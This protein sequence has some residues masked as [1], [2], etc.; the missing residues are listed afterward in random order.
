LEKEKI[1]LKDNFNDCVNE[2]LLK[3]LNSLKISSENII[4]LDITMQTA[5]KV[6]KVDEIN[7]KLK[8]VLKRVKS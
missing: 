2:L 7:E 1:K 3:G 8:E 5:K 4:L 6:G